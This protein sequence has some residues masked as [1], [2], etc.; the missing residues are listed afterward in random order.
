MN[1]NFPK[2]AAPIALSVV[3]LLTMTAC[4]DPSSSN[5]EDAYSNIESSSDSESL[6][7]AESS[8]E[9][10]GTTS[11]GSQI[12]SSS[13]SS[14]KVESSSD[15]VDSSVV[16]DSLSSSLQPESSSS[17]GPSVPTG[18]ITDAR[19]GKVYKVTQIGTQVWTAE[20]M[21]L[22]DSSLYVYEDA[23]KACPEGFHLPSIEEF[24]TLVEFVGGSEIAGKKLRSTTGWPKD[25]ALGDWNGTD[26]YGFGAKPVTLGN[27]TGTDENFWSRDRN[28]T[29]YYT[30]NFFKF[31]P[32]PTST[33]YDN[34]P[35][36][37]RDERFYFPFCEGREY[38]S[39]NRTCFVSGEPDTR[40]SVRCLS[41]LLDCGGKTID[42]K[43]QFCQDGAVYDLCRGRKYDGTKYTCKDNNLYDRATDSYYKYAWI[44]LDSDKEYGL[45][46]D[47]R[48]NQY[49]KTIEIDGVTWFAENLKY[50]TEE[51]ICHEFNPMH[52]DFY[53]RLYTHKQALDGATEVPSGKVQG[54]CPEGTH[55]ATYEE[56]A[57]LIDSVK[58]YDIE[59]EYFEDDYKGSV[60]VSGNTV[61]FSLIFP[62][63]CNKTQCG[64]EESWSYVN[65]QTHLI[66]SDGVYAI[67]DWNNSGLSKIKEVDDYIYGSVRCI[68]D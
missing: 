27:G 21:S 5:E 59:S 58:K 10:K 45:Y 41:D 26:D 62:G 64:T 66:A 3:L 49:Y 44:A 9:S 29:N 30:E 55:V 40:L 54:I 13:E 52:C 48:D 46:L 68:V 33:V 7:G 38:S 37:D 1:F 6:S 2:I 32:F 14:E 67:K 15:A 12:T 25:D 8:S 42:Y 53:G 28:Y 35:Q 56:Y 43:E 47:K 20:N 36:P 11:S 60:H 24:N 63:F 57:G 23:M 16:T 51:S 18:T 31:D 4:S 65:L 39:P 61:G 22:G 19:D 50:E 34:L 17:E